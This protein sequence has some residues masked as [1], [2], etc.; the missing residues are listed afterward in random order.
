M[1]SGVGCAV[2]SGSSGSSRTAVV[3]PSSASRC[4]SLFKSA[5]CKGASARL[6]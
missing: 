3:S 2:P 6:P 5:T 1:G 4:K